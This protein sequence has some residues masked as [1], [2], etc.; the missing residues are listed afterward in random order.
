MGVDDLIHPACAICKGSCCETLQ[1]PLPD[2]PD[3]ARWLGFHGK[4]RGG[5]VR[6]ETPC[7]KLVS[8]QCSVHADKPKVCRD[9][10]VGGDLCRSAVVTRRPPDVA[11]RIMRILIGPDR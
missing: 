2:D 1:F 11:A 9:F 7:S 10:E 5:R 6:L 4:V 3:L 8:G